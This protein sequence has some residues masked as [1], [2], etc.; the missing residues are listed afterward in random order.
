MISGR[1]QAA[2]LEGW[3]E[4]RVGSEVGAA[5]PAAIGDLEKVWPCSRGGTQALVTQAP[6]DHSLH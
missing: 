5:L 1:P 4:A 3:A 2:K 6:C